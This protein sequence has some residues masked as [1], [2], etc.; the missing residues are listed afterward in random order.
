MA[1]NSITTIPAE[2]ALKK[3]RRMVLWA[4]IGTLVVVSVAEIKKNV[5]DLKASDIRGAADVATAPLAIAPHPR[6]FIGG[7]VVF[8][9]LGM[10]VEVAPA[11]AKGFAALIF[12][13]AVMT[14]G[15]EA[16]N[17][18]A[19][20]RGVKGSVKTGVGAVADAIGN[21]GNQ[22]KDKGKGKGKSNP[23]DPRQR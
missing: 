21:V 11:I 22:V 13:G 1:T 4:M 14:R 8:F 2:F 17:A 15:P 16:F 20:A 6:V 10:L 3:S 9:V 7:L 23:T 12:V 5:K 19:K 18:L